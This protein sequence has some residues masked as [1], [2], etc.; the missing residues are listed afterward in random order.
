MET[1]SSFKVQSWL[2]WF[3]RGMLIF[4]FLILFARLIDLQIIRG[5]YYK[6]LAEG[7]RVRRV[8]IVAPR[9]N[10]YARNGELLVGNQE[11]KL[12]LTFDRN[13]G[14]Q[15]SKDVSGVAED[16]II[17]ESQRHYPYGETFAHITGYLGEVS[18]D[19]L[20]KI[21]AE[22]PEK[23]P[24]RIGAFVGRS[25][26]EEE[27]DCLLSGVDGEELIE[28]DALGQKVRTLGR[29]SPTPGSDLHT[30]ID[31]GLQTEIAKQMQ[32]KKG[33]V[34]V[35][36]PNGEVLALYSSPSYDPNVFV[37]SEDKTKVATLLNDSNL[38]LFNRVI[39]GKYHPGSVYKPLVAIASLEEGAINKD[40]T[41]NDTGQIV[42]NTVYGTFSYKNWYFTQYGGTEGKIGIVRALTRST[43]TF[44]Y[45]LGELVGV[46]KLV[47]W[48]Q[49]FG[50]GEKTGVDLP[51]E[52]AGF[53]P[54]PSWKIE[55]KKERWFLGNTYHMAIG[56]GDISLTP[57]GINTYISTIAADGN[58]CKPRILMRQSTKSKTLVPKD[59]KS[60]S[61]S[62]CKD[63]GIKKETL[64]LIKNGMRGACS[65]GGTGYTFFDFEEKT[66]QE[67]ACKTGTA[68]TENGEPHAWFTV[69]GPT[70]SPQ[71]ITTVLVENGGEGSKVAGPIA[72]SIFDYW[73]KVTPATPT[74]IP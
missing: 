34:I 71:I 37:S 68:E 27:Y 52:I 2:A 24:R 61:D 32:G 21:R 10:I 33:A 74:P 46:D 64:D 38:P 36:D 53:I 4:A 47:S 59:S 63:L 45:K 70:E 49:K 3:L 16:E 42:I 22:C 73:F 15:K 23:G 44:F 50:L 5:S 65:S 57:M 14:Y 58:L 18:E 67:V 55:E 13:G 39:S 30:T 51:S 11:V 66:G 72:R 6:S 60:S 20:G 40:F 17:S 26:L 31:F 35:S 29:K 54:S 62:Q 9:G 41:F 69:F 7:N 12:H 1:L 25:G 8:P 43:D 19:E 48:S 56:Q 28:V